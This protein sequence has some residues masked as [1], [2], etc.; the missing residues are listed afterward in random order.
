MPSCCSSWQEKAIKTIFYFYKNK[1]IVNF[2][3]RVKDAKDFV[4]ITQLFFDSLES[5][6]KAKWFKCSDTSWSCKG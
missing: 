3:C 1:P 2:Y 6:K 5:K 4:L